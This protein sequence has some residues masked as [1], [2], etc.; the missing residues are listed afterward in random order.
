MGFLE[1]FGLLGYLPKQKAK[2]RASPWEEVDGILEIC[3]LE[4]SNSSEVEP[5][6]VEG[7]LE[8]RR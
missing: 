8:G 4:W 5:F 2:C 7:R 3:S 6:L 1:A